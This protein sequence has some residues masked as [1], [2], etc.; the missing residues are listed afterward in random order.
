MTISPKEIVNSH[1][2]FVIYGLLKPRA[3][4]FVHPSYGTGV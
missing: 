3:P 2:S 4:D 1:L